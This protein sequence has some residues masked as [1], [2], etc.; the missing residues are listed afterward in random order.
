M[1]GGV[2]VSVRRVIREQFPQ[3]KQC[4]DL[5]T[6]PYG[7]EPEFKAPAKQMYTGLRSGKKLKGRQTVNSLLAGAAGT[8][9]Q[10]LHSRIGL[11]HKSLLPAFFCFVATMMLD[12]HQHD[13]DYRSVYLP[14]EPRNQKDA[15]ARP[16]TT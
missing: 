10:S 12:E 15:Y 16:S 1:A 5:T 3:A 4:A 14:A 11:K 2:D 13:L 7:P 8:N 6:Q 9:K